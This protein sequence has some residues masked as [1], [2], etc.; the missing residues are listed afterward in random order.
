MKKQY[1]LSPH[2]ETRVTPGMSSMCR[3]IFNIPAHRPVEFFDYRKLANILDECDR[4]NGGKPGE[5]Y[6]GFLKQFKL[7]FLWKRLDEK[8]VHELAGLLTPRVYF[9]S[10]ALY[11]D[12]FIFG[13]EERQDR[14]NVKVS[15]LKEEY[16]RS[17]EQTLNFA[18][19]TNGENSMIIR[20]ESCDVVFN[21]NWLDFVETPAAK[22]RPGRKYFAEMI[23]D[24]FKKAALLS[25]GAVTV[26]DIPRIRPVFI[27]DLKD[28]L[29]Y[30]ERGHDIANEYM[31]T[32]Q[33]SVSTW[34]RIDDRNGPVYALEEA[35]AEWAP[36]SPEKGRGAMSRLAEL[37]RL[38]KNRGARCLFVNCSNNWPADPGDKKY[39]TH[40]SLVLTGLALGVIANVSGMD[41]ERYTREKDTVW[42][43]LKNRHG[44]FINQLLDITYA[45]VFRI[46]EHEFTYPELEEEF[47]NV[48]QDKNAAEATGE[49]K[50]WE[51]WRT[52]LNCLKFFSQ[53]SWE[54]CRQV[55]QIEKPALERMV[56]EH[57]S[58]GRGEEYQN[59][60]QFI[61]T[62]CKKI[63]IC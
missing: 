51:Y 23:R 58:E 31:E 49:E 1:D 38:D 43:L 54:Q 59:L 50:N 36:D 47:F 29:Y 53:E 52:V 28:G 5:E 40:K 44:N 48:F 61:V 30:H 10:D 6:T 39:L 11:G 19:L 37:A 56:L 25:Y 20:Q 12:S 33:K 57:A 4:R 9:N 27:E 24:G 8:T 18:A 14:G 42:D 21:N 60:Y 13:L 63:G 46:R 34:F 3:S 7:E 32:H 16:I 41:T 2:G 17:P 26:K 55:Q 15:L 45:A 35:M 62:K 22:R